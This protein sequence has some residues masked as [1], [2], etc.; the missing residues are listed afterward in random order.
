LH[1]MARA[2][3]DAHM[4]LIRFVEECK[5]RPVAKSEAKK[6]RAKRRSMDLAKA[7]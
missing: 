2:I 1:L 3:F 5:E 6:Q 4:S 7:A